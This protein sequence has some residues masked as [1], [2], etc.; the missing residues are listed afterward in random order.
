MGDACAE[1][2]NRQHTLHMIAPDNQFYSVGE[3]TKTHENL[4]HRVFIQLST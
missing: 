1:Y 4:Q 2:I 3:H